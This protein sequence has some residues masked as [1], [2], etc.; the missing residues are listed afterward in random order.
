MNT[1]QVRAQNQ[2]GTPQKN[3]FGNNQQSQPSQPKKEEEPIQEN[4][5][6]GGDEAPSKPSFLHKTKKKTS[7]R[8][9]RQRQNRRLRKLLTPK[10]ALMA[11]YE[12]IGNKNCDFKISADSK[13]FF[14]EVLV[15]HIRYEGRGA[16][17]AAAKNDASEKA[18]RDLIIQKMVERPKKGTAAEN[19]DTPMDSDDAEMNDDSKGVEVPMMHLASYALHKLFSEWQNDGFEIPD[20]KTTNKDN[21]VPPKASAD[22]SDLPPNHENMHPSML[23]SMMRPNTQ[24]VDLGSE[25]TTP[26][27]VHRFGVTVDGKSFVGHDRTKKL[28]RKAAATAACNSCFGTKFQQEE[29][30][31]VANKKAEDN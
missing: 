15:N 4:V 16:S 1:R 31:V 20:L 29:I 30:R 8:E 3:N 24:Y 6:S 28:A 26:N 11:L 22:K 25:G 17:K 7:A 13:G 18:L 9:I 12:L 23:L 14:A 5:E 19:N 27:V 2:R 21:I 10:N